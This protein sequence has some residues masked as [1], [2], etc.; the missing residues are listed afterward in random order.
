MEFA[1]S[2]PS[3]FNLMLWGMTYTDGDGEADPYD[4]TEG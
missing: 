4:G 1:N 2:V 3:G